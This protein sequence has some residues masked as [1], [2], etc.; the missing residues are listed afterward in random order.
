M[1]KGVAITFSA[2]FLSLFLIGV[3]SAA[4]GLGELTRSAVDGI[5]DVIKPYVGILVNETDTSVSNDIF[6]A[7]WIIVLIVFAVVYLTLKKSTQFFDEHTWVLWIISLAVP[8]LGIRFLS[9]DLITTMLIPNAAFTVTVF[10][11]FPFVLTYL[12]TKNWTS[13]YGRRVAWILF[14]VVFLALYSTTAQGQFNYIYPLAA[15]L[16]LVMAAMDGTLAK[17]KSDAALDKAKSHAKLRSVAVWKKAL[18]R[19]E[20]EHNNNPAGY[21][22][23]H[24][25]V[26]MQNSLTGTRALTADVKYISEQI[27]LIS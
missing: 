7:K 25:P 5:I 19:A 26:A 27:K 9:S 17:F 10:A 23:Q 3:V 2:L 13:S 8:I 12:I 22:A 4:Q 18:A 20:A 6:M 24:D 15:I 14:A 21:V 11:G 1:K 16:A